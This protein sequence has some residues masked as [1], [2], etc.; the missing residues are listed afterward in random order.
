MVQSADVIPRAE[1][2]FTDF[3]VRLGGAVQ[4]CVLT[5]ALRGLFDLE[6]AGYNTAKTFVS[7]ITKLTRRR[8][9]VGEMGALGGKTVENSLGMF[10]ELKTHVRPSMTAWGF[11]GSLAS[12]FPAAS[13]L[14]LWFWPLVPGPPQDGYGGLVPRHWWSAA[15]YMLQI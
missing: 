12:G 9:L 11:L 15:A 1:K 13:P 3:W 10:C 8:Q 6:H 2:W 4:L 14:R 7:L 5:Q